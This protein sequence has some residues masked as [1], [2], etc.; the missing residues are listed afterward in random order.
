MGN[1][2][3]EH[4]MEKRRTV[5]LYGNS[6]LMAGMEISLRDQPGLDVVRIDT[7]LPDAAQR[8]SALQ[9]NVVIFDLATPPSNPSTTLGTGFQPPT[10]NLQPPFSRNTQAFH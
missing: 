5:V 6:L 3:Q 9:P 10:L 8:L 7:T 2:E 4:G 1:P